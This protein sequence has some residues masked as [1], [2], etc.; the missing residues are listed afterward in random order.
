MKYATLT[1]AVL[2]LCAPAAAQHHGRYGE[3]AATTYSPCKPHE[4]PLVD[5]MPAKDLKF[6]VTAPPEIQHLMNQGLTLFYAFNYDHA[7]IKFSEA[8]RKASKVAM[9]HWGVALAAGANINIGMDNEC[10]DQAVAA[11]KEAVRLA[12]EQK[13]PPLIT[14]K[15]IDYIQALEMR[16]LHADKATIPLDAEYKVAMER[17]IAK[18]KYP[19]DPNVLTLYADSVMELRPWGLYDVAARP[20]IETEEMVKK[21]EHAIAKQEG[22][23]GANH[24]YIHAVEP[25]LTPERAR[26]SAD[27]LASL[28]PQGGHIQHMPGHIYMRQGLYDK[29]VANN[30][31]AIKADQEYL[32]VCPG[33]KCLA[34]YTGHY[35]SHNILFL[36]AG[37]TMLGQERP[38]TE[39]ADWLR[40]VAEKF[41]DDQPGLERYMTAGIFTR[42]TFHRWDQLPTRQPADKYPLALAVWHWGKGMA[43]AAQGGTN[44]TKAEGELTTFAKLAGAVSGR[45][46]GN[47]TADS[48]LRIAQQTLRARIST[49]KKNLPAAIEAL[50]VAVTLEDGLIYDEPPPWIYPARQS[51]GGALLA[52]KQYAEAEKYFR[53]DL[54]KP[55]FPD[56]GRSNYGLAVSLKCQ[57]PVKDW[58]SA[59]DK[60][61]ELWKKK[62]GVELTVGALWSDLNEPCAKMP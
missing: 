39:N 36:I 44:V 60:Y 20:A 46:W 13:G 29:V 3:T 43:F 21:L 23:L 1:I 8:A 47:N 10:R 45:S 28:F 12:A 16:Y 35:L 32:K 2:L 24:Y 55:R 40:T 56:N 11:I 7:F 57:V 41:V 25:S 19:D 33:P 50:K 18:D 30:L 52:D 37:H 5:V 9:A 14:Q 4:D 59:Y 53:Q 31:E 17:L 26:A 62:G 38:A 15:E 49:A 42:A 54:E 22:H 51:L 48:L 27:R 58:K 34:L 6:H 61:D